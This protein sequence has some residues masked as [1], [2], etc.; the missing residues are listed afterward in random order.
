MFELECDTAWTFSMF[1]EWWT[2]EYIMRLHSHQK[3]VNLNMSRWSYSPSGLPDIGLT[4]TGWGIVI[5]EYKLAGL[6]HNLCSFL[7]QLA[8]TTPTRKGNHKEQVK[9]QWHLN[10]LLTGT[11]GSIMKWMWILMQVFSWFMLLLDDI[12]LQLSLLVPSLFSLPKLVSKDEQ[13]QLCVLAFYRCCSST[14]KLPL[15]WG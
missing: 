2:N 4:K 6:W 11:P 5:V 15:R 12:P 7:A 1:G 9:T 10:T 13:S 14:E 8:P 3:P